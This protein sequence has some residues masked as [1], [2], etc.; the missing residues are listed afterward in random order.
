MTDAIFAG[1]AVLLVAAVAAS[2]FFDARR[3]RSEMAALDRQIADL[4]R[5][6]KTEARPR[7]KLLQGGRR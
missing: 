4:E 5:Q 1:F 2:M 7:L 6:F 3:E